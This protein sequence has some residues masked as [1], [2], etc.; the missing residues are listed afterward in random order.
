MNDPHDPFNRAPLTFDQVIPRPDL[1][2]KIEDY[3]E[4]K[5]AIKMS[6]KM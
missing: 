6:M 3:K 1:K 4:E 5:L 2:Y